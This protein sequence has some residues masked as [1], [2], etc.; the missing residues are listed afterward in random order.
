[1]RGQG[2]DARRRR[3]LAHTPGHL[4]AVD[5]WHGQV[6]QQHIRTEGADEPQRFLSIRRLPDHLHALR[7]VQQFGGGFAQQ[8]VIVRK[9][10]PNHLA[11]RGHWPSN[12]VSLRGTHRRTRVPLPPVAEVISRSAPISAARSRIPSRPWP[13]W[14]AEVEK[15]WPE[16]ATH[17]DS[18]SVEKPSS[19]SAS[20]TPAWRA[21]LLSASCATR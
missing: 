21:T 14:V 9:H 5:T 4:D 18:S 15:P 3:Q 20:E 16:S 1:V 2:H 11:G 19:S 12:T 7:A 8:R 13:G 6:Q 10:D 17:N